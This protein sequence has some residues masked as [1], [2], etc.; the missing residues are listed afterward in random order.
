MA[1]G[2]GDAKYGGVCTARFMAHSITSTFATTVATNHLN[3][4]LIIL[5]NLGK[6]ETVK[7][8]SET[9]QCALNNTK[10][11]L[12]LAHLDPQ[13]FHHPKQQMTAPKDRPRSLCRLS[14][15]MF[16]VQLSECSSQT[17]LLGAQEFLL[18]AAQL[19]IS[20]GI[21][22]GIL[23]RHA[24]GVQQAHIH[25]AWQSMQYQWCSR[26]LFKGLAWVFK[27]VIYAYSKIP[28]CSK[29]VSCNLEKN[30]KVVHHPGPFKFLRLGVPDFANWAV[31]IVADLAGSM[32]TKRLPPGFM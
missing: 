17:V 29:C 21:F 22:Q 2:V 6:D 30:F 3:T 25:G 7:F 9:C 14:T 20:H 27:V 32:N 13:S 26:D 31:S 4:T 1:A 11:H 15:G 19:G 5:Y 18:H 10:I 16:T 8:F 23:S 24:V 28:N 12:E